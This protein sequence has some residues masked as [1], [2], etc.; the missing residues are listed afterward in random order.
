MALTT[1]TMTREQ[2][3]SVALEYLKRLDRGDDFF[4]LFA[5]DAQLYF[6][7]YGVVNGIDEIQRVYGSVG[8]SSPRSG[9]T[10]PTSTSSARETC[11]S[12]KA[13]ARARRTSQNLFARLC[14]W[15]R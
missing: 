6:P 1:Q 13:R 11:S 15:P 9:T 12:P 2:M 7:K 10:T 4:D 8:R 5:D 14:P 3:K